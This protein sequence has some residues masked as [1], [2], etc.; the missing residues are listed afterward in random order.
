M[1]L[2]DN[3]EKSPRSES[4]ISSFQN[5]INNE[6]SNSDILSFK[7]ESQFNDRTFE[8]ADFSES[9]SDIA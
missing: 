9:F 2:R 8:S 5:G 7:S 4:A 3:Q 6:N 1:L